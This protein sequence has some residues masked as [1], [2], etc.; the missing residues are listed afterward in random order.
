LHRQA[1]QEV[2]HR[3]RTYLIK[4]AQASLLPGP[5]QEINP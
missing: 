3:Y 4:Q 1:R 2:I 5:I